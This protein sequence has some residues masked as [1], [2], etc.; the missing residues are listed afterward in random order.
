[1]FAS[2]QRRPAPGSAAN[3]LGPPVRIGVLTVFL[4][5]R[6]LSLRVRGRSV[7]TFRV[8]LHGGRGVV[9]VERGGFGFDKLERLSK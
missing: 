7:E 4:L 6:S 9:D 5:S 1:V 2:G 8:F 3:R